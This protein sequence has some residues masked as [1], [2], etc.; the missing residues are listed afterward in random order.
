MASDTAPP[1]VP[2]PSDPPMPAAPPSAPA[3]PGGGLAGLLSAIDPVRTTHAFDL[4]PARASAHDPADAS[5]GA[6]SADFNHDPTATAQDTNSTTKNSQQNTG[7]WRTWIL[8]LAKRH[9]QAGAARLKA[10]DIKKAQATALQ[11]K[12]QRTTNR[13]EKIVGG[14]TGS[15]T[16][17]Q[18]KADKNTGTS[19]KNHSSG[20]GTKNGGGAKN[21]GA[22]GGRPGPSGHDGSGSGGG[23]NGGGHGSGGGRG[24]TNGPGGTGKPNSKTDLRKS[25]HGKTPSSSGTKSPGTGGGK[26]GPAGGKGAAGPSGKDGKT[27]SPTSSGSG[28]GAGG[29]GKG[30]KPN[31]TTTATCGD[32][33][34]IDLAKKR[35]EA[36]VKD[37]SPKAE[38]KAPSAGTGKTP[39]S[40]SGG[41]GGTGGR[42][43]ADTRKAPAPVPGGKRADLKKNPDTKGGPKTTAKATP[44]T[45]PKKDPKT[46]PT[47]APGP[48]IDTQKARETGYRDGTRI[49][50]AVSQAGAYKDGLGDGY[51][52]TRD[53]SAREKDRLDKAHRDRKKPTPVAPPKPAFPPKP[54][55][56]PATG[57]DTTKTAPAPT[58]SKDKP[59]T[60]TDTTATPVQVK[61]IN[62]RGLELGDGAARLT[63]SRGEVRT[64]KH[65]ERALDARTAAL[66]KAAENT[67]VCQAEAI[68]YATKASKLLEEAKA[69]KGGEKLAAALTRL[70]ETAQLQAMKA[71]ETHRRAVRAADTCRA[72]VSNL[73]TRYEP[74]YQAVVNS[75]ETSPAETNFYLGDHSG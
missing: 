35:K 68:E 50:N 73:K 27:T 48:R 6:S 72:L 30:K 4:D 53:A 51:R 26:G 54:T 5:G 60:T 71:G 9:E 63:I 14:N 8:A 13:S 7:I 21:N 61:S 74:L 10:L 58:P 11:V 44:A 31:T 46:T 40:G 57:P 42:P 32:G 70:Q 47:P 52:D 17:T 18:S 28:G 29:L 25:D 75:P 67:K 38:P 55:T 1:A 66:A 49:G 69:V 20:G 23:R 64:L 36:A 34:G 41:P 24:Q 12:E 59:M 62:A 43:G 56:P 15:G 2:A 37:A 16:N 65:F 45:D 3:Q 22:S 33:S 39:P 19:S